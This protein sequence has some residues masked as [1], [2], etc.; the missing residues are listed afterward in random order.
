ALAYP[1]R[2]EAGVEALDL[3]QIAKLTFLAPDVQRFPC[4]GL[5]YAA[6]EEGGSAPALLNAANE[7]AV[8]AF[9]DG[10]VGFMD[11]PRIIGDVLE[12]AERFPL[13]SLDA[14]LAADAIGRRW[15]IQIAGLSTSL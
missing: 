2:V 9:L 1:E 8:A 6:L 14:V 11:I 3:F 10:R 7:V 13:A 12:R 5:A 15:A 4:L